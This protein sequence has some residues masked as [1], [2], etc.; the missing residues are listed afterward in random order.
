[1][2][3]HE[4]AAASLNDV[5]DFI[6]ALAW[7]TVA[8]VALFMLISPRGVTLVRAISRRLGRVKWRDIEIE[9]KPE[10][11]TELKRDLEQ[12][13]RAYRDRVQDVFDHQNHVERVPYLRDSVAS[14][15]IKPRLQGEDQQFRCTV[16]VPDPLFEDALYCLLDY[17]PKGEA[18]G[19]TYSIRFG[20]VG[21]AWRT[22][23]SYVEDV[24]ADPDELM[25]GW[26]M[27]AEEA[28]SIQDE[29]RAFLAVVLRAD[30]LPVGVLYA[31]ASPNAFPA[32]LHEV[33]LNDDRTIALASA[34]A[35][36]SQTLRG[37]G[38]AI[39][40]FERG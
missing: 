9:L 26:G 17:Y 19:R 13:F 22:G 24:P 14:E 8:L 27:T 23:Q 15:V 30:N 3:G 10:A 37:R 31:D 11:A 4:L 38:P 29:D 33:V 32:D 40:I 35:N 34:V 39:R 36:V 20:I 5:A 18:R 12:T 21:R 25:R 6:R 2:A 16:Y 28:Q 7:P 1:M